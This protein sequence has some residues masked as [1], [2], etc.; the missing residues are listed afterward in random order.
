[1]AVNQIC[2]LTVEDGDCQDLLAMLS[3]NVPT[4]VI[5][6]GIPGSGKSTVAEAISQ[7]YPAAIHSTDRYHQLDGEH[8]FQPSRLGEFHQKNQAAFKLSILNKVQVV[9]CDNA[10][11]KRWEFEPYL[12]A[13]KGY[14]QI[15]VLLKADPLE[16][17]ERGIHGVPEK[18]VLQMHRRLEP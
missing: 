10:N 16:A 11:I 18:K 8:L 12:K 17:A 6:R 9:V 5:L 14:R 1:M 15:V 3:D 2:D 7:N 4:V 13:A